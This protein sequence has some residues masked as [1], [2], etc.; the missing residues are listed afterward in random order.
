MYRSSSKTKELCVGISWASTNPIIGDRKSVPPE[1]WQPILR[2]RSV[3]FFNLQ[4]GPMAGE[5]ENI[6]TTLGTDVFKDPSLDIGNDLDSALCQIGAM[7]LVIAC[8]NTTAHLAGASGV[9]TW[10]LVP[11]GR[12]RLWYW[13][14]GGQKCPWYQNLKLLS[15]GTDWG[16]VRRYGKGCTRPDV[17]IIRGEEVGEPPNSSINQEIRK[18]LKVS[19][20]VG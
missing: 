16:L 19:A 20:W 8:S 17:S 14:L 4:Q 18:L 1:L 15:Q 12:A 11:T 6:S 3:R 2:C 7:D 9:P 5:M 13:F 10:V